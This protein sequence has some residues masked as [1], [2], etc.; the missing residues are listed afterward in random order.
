MFDFHIYMLLII[1]DYD[2]K[3]LHVYVLLAI[4]LIVMKDD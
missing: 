4:Y 1:F 3:C 2:E